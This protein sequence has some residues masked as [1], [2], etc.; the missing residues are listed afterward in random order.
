M[1]RLIAAEDDAEVPVKRLRGGGGDGEPPEADYF[2]D[3]EPMEEIDIPEEVDT[4]AEDVESDQVVFSDITEDMR[5]RWLRPANEIT[6]NSNDVNLQWFDMD[7]IG[8][9]AL[10]RN[11]NESKNRVVGATTGQVPVV[12]AYGTTEAG[13][14][15]ALFIHGFTPY[16]YFALPANATFENTEENLTKIRHCINNR[17][18][19]AVRGSHHSEYCRAVSYVTSHKSI[20]GYDTR[21]TLFFKVMLAMP[22]MVPTL[23]RIMEDGIE[24]PGVKTSGDNFYQAFECNVPYVL[25]YMIDLD[26]SGAGWLSLPK[27]SYSV[28]PESKKQTHCQASVFLSLT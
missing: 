2:L 25:R 22:T 7:V 21:H 3:E 12:R 10:E 27:K 14:S 19:G 6:D 13:N 5:K 23:K 16:G 8:G 28:R 4:P 11:P 24:L 15:V 17:L 26:I 9:S 20:M 1:K 18:E